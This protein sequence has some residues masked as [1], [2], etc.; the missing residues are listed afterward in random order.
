MI[1]QGGYMVKEMQPCLH[2]GCHEA[3]ADRLPENRLTSL[4]EL[5][6][7]FGD[8]TRLR[9]LTALSGGEMCVQHL[10]QAVGMSSS[11]VSHQLK[12]LKNAKLVNFRREGKTVLYSLADA[13]VSTILMQGLDHI[14]E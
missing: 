5:F 12:T 8:P 3:S 6:K 9:I 10:S 14:N 4:A 1:K 2:T 11:A 7:V 13:H